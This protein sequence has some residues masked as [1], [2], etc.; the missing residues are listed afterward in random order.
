MCRGFGND[1]AN[2][3]WFL[4]VG[5]DASPGIGCLVQRLPVRPKYDTPSDARIP[6]ISTS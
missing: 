5:R 2:G 3:D 6:E 1:E 4:S